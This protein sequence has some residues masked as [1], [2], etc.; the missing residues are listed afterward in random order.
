MAFLF[1]SPYGTGTLLRKE[2]IFRG[3]ISSKTKVIEKH[4]RNHDLI[5]ALQ[6]T[7]SA[8]KM[9]LRIAERAL[10]CPVFGRYKI[11]KNLLQQVAEQIT[12]MNEP[13]RLVVQCTGEHFQRH[14]L[15]RWTERELTSRGCRLSSRESDR[16]VWLMTIDEDFYFGLPFQLSEDGAWLESSKKSEER[17]GSLPVEMAAAMVFEAMMS[18]D[19]I[20]WD[21]V[22]GSGTLLLQALTTQPGAAVFGS[23]IDGHAV[24]IAKQNI[25]SSGFESDRVSI[26]NQ[27]STLIK[28]IAENSISLVLAN[29]PFGKQYGS[30]ETNAGLYGQLLGSISRLSEKTGKFRAVVLTSDEISLRTAVIESQIFTISR[31]RSVKVR[32]E[33]AQISILKLI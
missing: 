28:E 2:L 29:L 9:P 3:V 14:D 25:S 8:P 27:D 18:A 23:D 26:M 5:L 24:S 16:A 12:A 10:R 11:S 1:L 21:P 31:Q 30:R 19:D 33:E 13:L 32:G 15:L 6:S 7:V 22:C 20:V 17:A 4:L